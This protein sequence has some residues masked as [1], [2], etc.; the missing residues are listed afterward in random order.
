MRALQLVCATASGSS[1][2]SVCPMRSGA[3]SP[4]DEEAVTL[5]GVPIAVRGLS[6]AT[7]SGNCAAQADADT[8][9]AKLAA[10]N[11]RFIETPNG[12]VHDSLDRTEENKVG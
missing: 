10:S 9:V 4:L 11:L 8:T 3:A 12:S 1:P 6:L 2:S 5:A 7:A